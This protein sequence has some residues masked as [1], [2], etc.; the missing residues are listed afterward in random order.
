MNSD[1]GPDV[2]QAQEE[3]CRDQTSQDVLTNA[4]AGRQ[5]WEKVSADENGMLGDVPLWEG[6]GAISK[7]ELQGSRTFLARLGI[8]LK[9]GRKPLVSVLEGGAGYVQNR[10]IYV[11]RVSLAS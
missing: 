9:A 1:R 6:F 5:Y 7:I 11:R 8:G 3:R 10:M 2:L 4:E